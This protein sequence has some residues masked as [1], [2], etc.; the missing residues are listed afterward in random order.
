[1]AA[2]QLIA[3][4]T[5]HQLNTLDSL[6][7]KELVNTISEAFAK[8]K[9]CIIWQKENA[10]LSV[11]QEHPMK[12]S[13]GNWC[14]GY[15]IEKVENGVDPVSEQQKYIIDFT[16]NGFPKNE[17]ANFFPDFEICTFEFAI[18]QMWPGLKEQPVSIAYKTGVA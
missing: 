11:E 1:V 12:E 4:M 2:F 9:Y 17:I 18:K 3:D 8:S 7:N 5:E 13:S 10:F 14:K 16:E 15:V 6:C